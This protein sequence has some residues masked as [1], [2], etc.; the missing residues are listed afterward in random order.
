M[1]Y[2]EWLLFSI[3]DSKGVKLLSRLRLNFNHL[4]EHKFR[5]NFKNCMSHMCGC[6][7]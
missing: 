2:N 3:H 7:L 1:K 6:R 5:Q 4:N